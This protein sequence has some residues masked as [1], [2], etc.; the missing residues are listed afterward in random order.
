[1]PSCLAPALARFFFLGPFFTKKPRFEHFAVDDSKA[2]GPECSCA[3]S[4]AQRTRCLLAGRP[5]DK[6]RGLKPHFSLQSR[7]LPRPSPVVQHIPRVAWALPLLPPSPCSWFCSL[8]GQLAL[9]GPS[10]GWGA[11]PL[12]CFCHRAEQGAGGS[13]E[14]QGHAEWREE[15]R[16]EGRQHQAR[17]SHP[18]RVFVS[19]SSR[20]SPLLRSSL[21]GRGAQGLHVPGP[22][23][24]LLHLATIFFTNF[25]F[26]SLR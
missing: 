18:T 17:R 1:M 25:F 7:G 11:E 2:A 13:A 6:S 8:R 5:R 9:P 20:A 16:E 12:T 3:Q 14:A 24:P 4:Q 22:K 23:E 19:H 10:R 21:Q 15:Q 26:I